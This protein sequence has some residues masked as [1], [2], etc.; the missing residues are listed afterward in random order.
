MKGGMD[1]GGLLRGSFIYNRDTV[2]PKT[3]YVCYPHFMNLRIQGT[4]LLR[5]AALGYD[6]TDPG[7]VLAHKIDQ[8]ILKELTTDVK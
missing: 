2:L 5:N 4:Q 3:I 1:I 8:D 7:A 6:E